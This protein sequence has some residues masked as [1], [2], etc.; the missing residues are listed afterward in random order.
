MLLDQRRSNCCGD[1]SAKAAVRSNTPS[2][3]FG[4]IFLSHHQQPR[5]STTMPAQVPPCCTPSASSGAPPH[6]SARKLVV[7]MVAVGQTFSQV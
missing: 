4:M 6:F 7:R 5:P 3:I 1:E 2:L